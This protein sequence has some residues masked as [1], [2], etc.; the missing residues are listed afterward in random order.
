ME[1]PREFCCSV[2]KSEVLLLSGQI[3]FPKVGLLWV[4]FTIYTSKWPP[5]EVGG[6]VAIQLLDSEKLELLMPLPSPPT[7]SFSPVFTAGFGLKPHSTN[8]FVVEQS[9]F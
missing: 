4:T 9:I 1:E 3:Q 6:G 5:G 8:L 2:Q 7:H